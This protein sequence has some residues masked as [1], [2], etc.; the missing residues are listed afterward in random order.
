[1]DHVQSR[2]SR[3]LSRVWPCRRH[4]AAVMALAVAALFMLEPAPADCATVDLGKLLAGSGATVSLSASNIYILYNE[5]RITKDQTLRC[6][7]ASIQAQGVLKAMGAGVDVTLDQCVINSTSWG[8]V[9][10]TDSAS[11]TITGSTLNCP[12]GTGVYVKDAAVEVGQTSINNCQYGVNIE[13]AAN[14]D[15]H[16]VT[17]S[18][19]PYAAQISGSSGVLLIDQQS[20]FTNSGYGTG[21]G[22]AN[23]ARITITDTMIQNF[24]YG[25]NLTSGATASLSAVTLDGCPYAAQVSGTSSQLDVAGGSSFRY[26]GY[27]TGVGI[28]QGAQ[29]IIQQTSFE[30]FSNAVDVQPPNSGTVQVTDST[31]L[32]NYVSAL[33]VVGSRDVLFSNCTVS[34]AQ[35]D[36]VYFNN[37]TGVVEKSEIVDSLNTGVTFMGCPN[38][39]A[40]RNSYVSG[41]VHQGIAVGKDDITG[42]PSYDIEISDNTV[43]GNQLANVFVDAV[44]TASLHGNIL[45]DSPQAGVRLH[46]SK[47]ITLVA[48]LLNGSLLGVELK[49]SGNAAMTLS[50][51]FGNAGDGLLVYDKG[52]LTIDHNAF[53]GN[54]LS[55]G[56]AWSLFMN[57]GAVVYGQYNSLGYSG[58]DALYNNAG[59]TATVTN[60]YWGAATG[61]KT[62]GGSGTGAKL[63]WNV[64]TGSSV[65]YSPYLTSAP[66][67]LATQSN[68]SATSGQTLNWNSGQGVVAVLQLGSFSSPLSNQTLGVLHA[69]DSKHLNQ[70]LPAPAS[71]EGQLY[72]AWASEPL[73]RAGQAAY[74]VFSAPLAQGPVYL[75]RR[76][77]AGSWVTIPSVWDAAT[78]T[79]T[80]TFTNPY[81]L[82]GTFALTSAQP[83][84]PKDVEALVVHFYQTI[85][86]R[87][88]EAGAVDAWETGY[89]NYALSFN[90][91]VRYIPTEMGRLFFLSTE[92]A[93]RHRNDTEFI[94][95]CYQAF[96]YRAPEPGAV[97]QWTQGSWNRAEAMSLFAESDEFRDRIAALFPGFEGDPSRNLVTVLFIGLLD[98]LPDKGG[99][100]SW[101]DR[102]DASSDAKATAKEFGKAAVASSEFQGFQASNQDIVIHL[103]RAYMGRFP[104]DS[105]ASYWAD[106]LTHGVYTVDQLIDR[107][108][109]ST[110]FAERLDSI[111]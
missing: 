19:T 13:G 50:A 68:V 16:G 60:N 30:G 98:R 18:N 37:S 34:G 11:V 3:S 88:P 21:V 64:N 44:S 73:R 86:G 65:I 7:G 10:A 71:L 32:N 72:V 15:L 31:F 42:T 33:S 8:A 89:F 101:S 47:D 17:S 1:M 75:A 57:T 14:V 111:Y 26:L 54:G 95:D 97:E 45:T 4:A 25:V 61:P 5:Y 41:S 63:D 77:F 53:N 59:T 24:A 46:G 40:I 28:L 105:E 6:Q 69:A 83:P 55:G 52:S 94:T 9:A 36:G 87:N 81:Q 38:G 109:D 66:V 103:Y 12:G 49:D 80:G 92:Y 85:L 110:E 82:N 58:D 27:G 23:G 22:G 106:M 91:D 51:V 2:F 78:H 43:T 93:N 104:N 74:L 39:A 76:S 102:F 67:S 48:N 90:I 100:L 107:F 29:A 62:V 99:L 84:D 70:I 108:A 20:S 96:L 79:V 35:A 56:N